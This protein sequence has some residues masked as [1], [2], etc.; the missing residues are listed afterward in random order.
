MQKKLLYK[1]LIIVALMLLIGLP[2]IMIDGTI[3]ERMRFHQQAVESIANDSVR[4]QTVIGPVLVLPY[5]EEIKDGDKLRTVTHRKLVFPNA[6]RIAGRI[7]AERRYRGIHQV[8]MFKGGHSVAGDFSVPPAADFARES[9]ASQLAMGKPYIALAVTDVRGIRDIPNMLVAGQSHRF[10]HGAR[11]PAYTSGMHVPL[12]LADLKAAGGSLP[13]GFTLYLSGT[14]RQ[15][16]VP[17]GANNV[18]TIES[19]W[20]HPQFAGSFLPESR[21][22]DDSG[23]KASWRISAMASSAQQQLQAMDGAAPAQAAEARA[24]LDS[25]GMGFIEP[26]N[27]YAQADRA[28]KYGLL[29]VALTF[30]AFFV[31]EILKALPIHPIQYLLVGL[32]LIM[33]FLLLVSLSEH[34][35]FLVSY[36]IASAACIAL[37]TF[38]LSAVLRSRARAAGFG[39]GLVLLYSALY[40]LLSSENNAL[41]LGTLLLFTALGAVM[42]ATRKVDWYGIGKMDESATVP[43]A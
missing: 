28:T 35:D 6:L 40:G 21:S 3:D 37:I 29:F 33:F 30:A 31:F 2:L 27:V 39:A 20:P 19:N 13:F 14:E 23:F 38:Y 24:R 1:C 36:L 9:G 10:E 41:V 25:F 8:L 26:V 4:E 42:I 34:L 15:N 12:E 7:N 32:A 16:F 5:T 22:I 18:V 17:V 11:L 43:A